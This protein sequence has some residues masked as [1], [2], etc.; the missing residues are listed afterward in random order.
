MSEAVRLYKYQALLAHGRAV[1]RAQLMA[2]NEI[3]LATF[4][5]DIA[6]LR[7]QL[8]VPVE[9]DHDQRGYVLRNST[10]RQELPGFWLSEQEIV[11]LATIQ[12]MISQMAPSL[13]G[14]KLA[15]LE[16]KL[17]ELLNKHGL[18]TRDLGRRI[19]LLYAGKRQMNSTVFETVA[20]ATFDRRRLAVRHLNRSTSETIEREISPIDITLYRGNWYVNA[21]CH[22]R[23]DLRRF[24]VDAIEH[25]TILAEQAQEV[26]EVCVEQALGAGYGIFSGKRMQRAQL[27]FTPERAN[28]VKS[29]EWHP[30]QVGRLL[31]DGSY[32]LEVPYTDEREILADLM[33]YGSGVEVL[34][35]PALRIA[36]KKALHEAL[37]K[38][39]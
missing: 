17:E 10:G 27:C 37:G 11:A 30:E 34:K 21:W 20:H 29:E 4:K 32:Q 23:D 16:K 7:D 18:S 9:Y 2:A 39:L 22:L 13:L 36:M 15:P 24:A 26:D 5:R 14:P 25:A 35:P 12:K 6:K 8:G 19:K 1:S 3:S 31:A 33:R 28:W 38:Y